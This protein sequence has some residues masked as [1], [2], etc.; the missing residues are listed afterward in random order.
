MHLGARVLLEG[1]VVEVDARVVGAKVPLHRQLLLPVLG[2]TTAGIRRGR[3]VPR[4]RSAAVSAASLLV[5][6]RPTGLVASFTHRRV[7]GRAAA[8]PAAAAAAAVEASI[9]VVR[10]AFIALLMTQTPR[11]LWSFVH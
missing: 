11:V 4:R 3:G 9:N 2:P 1:V 10:F 6:R 8:V 7:A 5:D